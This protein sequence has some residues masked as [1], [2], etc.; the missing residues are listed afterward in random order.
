MMIL[1]LIPGVVAS[2]PL[3]AYY[4]ITFVNL[5]VGDSGITSC[6]L[7]IGNKCIEFKTG[8]YPGKEILTV[9]G[10]PLNTPTHLLLPRTENNISIQLPEKFNLNAEYPELL[11]FYHLSYS[12]PMEKPIFN[13]I[14]NVK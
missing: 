6:I 3:T 13:S 2:M 8:N 1:R 12:V 5:Y 9:N 4:S 14:S 10:N 7:K 11:L